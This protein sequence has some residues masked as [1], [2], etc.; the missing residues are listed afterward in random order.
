[1][2][3]PPAPIDPAEFVLRRVHRSHYDPSLPVPVQK[4]AACPNK[5]DDKGL[6]VFREQ[7][8][9]ADPRG[10]LANVDPTKRD[11]ILIAR[12]RVADL[13]AIGLTVVPDEGPQHLPG[14]CAIPELR[15]AVYEADKPA[16]ADTILA[17]AKLLS[18]GMI[19]PPSTA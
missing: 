17:L 3:A 16:L 13:N 19:D 6:S 15:R 10:I 1:M 14:H 8:Y 9:T 12:V 18:R 5:N 7:N 4:A 11:N 2:D